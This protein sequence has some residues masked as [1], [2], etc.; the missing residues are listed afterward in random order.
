[1][2][3]HAIA[4]RRHTPRV[5]RYWLKFWHEFTRMRTAIYFLI[6]IIAITLVGA[7]V[8]QQNTDSQTLVDSFLASHQHLNSLA[9]AIG[10]P[11]T[12]VF[13]SPLFYALVAAL[14][15]SLG[16]CVLRRGQALIVRT[17]RGYKRNAQYWGEW[18][19]WLFHTSFFLILI[20][21]IWGK[22]TGFDGLLTIIQG[23]TVTEAAASYDSLDQGVL[24]NGYHTNLQLHLNSFVAKYGAGG[25]ASLYK[26]SLTVYQ[27]GK[28]ILTRNVEVNHYLAIDGIHIYQQDYGW[29]PVITV[30]NPAG[31]VVFSSPIECFGENKSDETCVLK[32]PDFNYTVPGA[33]HPL[34]VGAQMVMLP[35]ARPIVPVTNSGQ[36]N[37]IGTTY[38][39]GGGVANNPVVGM[40]LFIGNLGL[41]S[42][43]P[44]NVDTLD[45][46]QMVPYFQNG[47]EVYLPL[48]T[49]LK[50]QLPGANGTSVPFTISFT[51]L[52]PYSLFQISKDSGVP[53][54]YVSFFLIMLGI[55]LKL[56]IKPILD[57][58][59]KAIRVSQKTRTNGSSQSVNVPLPAGESQKT[60]P[61][62]DSAPREHQNV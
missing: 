23:Q 50:L 12:S 29:A 49:T 30:R 40:Q 15:L 62:T 37:T 17:V 14:Y 61:L 45:V 26:S 27:H 6:A 3:T 25:V 35:D 34:Q 60:P 31:Q 47:Q 22:A 19:S 38:A 46:S 8:P 58:R 56:Y 59:E 33:K 43:V 39:P 16:W 48:G 55:I 7:F 13:V 52:K 44:Q 24:S 42:G 28:P 20:A 11:L 2:T 9:S 57:K 5:L 53:L 36:L 32:V 21:A 10:L 18:G 51:S 54:V 41:T 4:K 1:M